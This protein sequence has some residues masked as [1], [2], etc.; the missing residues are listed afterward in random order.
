MV[1]IITLRNAHHQTLCAA[2][3]IQST[4]H[5]LILYVLS[6]YYPPIYS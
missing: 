1:Y 5:I 4:P 3:L 6:Q 2:I